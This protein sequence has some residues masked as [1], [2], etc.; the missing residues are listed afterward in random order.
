M[1]L[2]SYKK[3]QLNKQ[4]NKNPPGSTYWN[5]RKFLI[6]S[7]QEARYRTCGL[8]IINLPE[9]PYAWITRHALTSPSPFRERIFFPIS[10]K[11]LFGDALAHFVTRSSTEMRY[12]RKKR[13]KEKDRNSYRLL[14]ENNIF[15]F[16]FL[17]F[18]V[19]CFRNFYTMGM[20]VTNTDVSAT[21]YNNRPCVRNYC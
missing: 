18:A 5:K 16:F 1:N 20:Y 15:L 8:S 10:V 13:K 19:Y 4:T 9:T 7:E 17:S 14:M 3:K 21:S 12:T 11:I 6:S 2:R